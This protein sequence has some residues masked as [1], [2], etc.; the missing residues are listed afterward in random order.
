MVIVSYTLLSGFVSQVHRFIYLVAFTTATRWQYFQGPFRI[1]T[2]FFQNV[3]KRNVI[4][5]PSN[6]C[7]IYKIV[8]SQNHTFWDV[9]Y[10]VHS[11]NAVFQYQQKHMVRNMISFFQDDLQTSRAYHRASNFCFVWLCMDKGVSILYPFC[12]QNHK[13]TTPKT[14][15]KTS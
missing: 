1:H 5:T 12:P 2:F 13:K 11:F 14:T 7:L 8:F 6:E 4:V 9:L 10:H 3:P 15:K